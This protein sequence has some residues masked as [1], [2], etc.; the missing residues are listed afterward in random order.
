MAEPVT[1]G[2]AAASFLDPTSFGIGVVGGIISRHI[3]PAKEPWAAHFIA[4][5]GN[6]NRNGKLP[7]NHDVEAACFDALANTLR[8]L[9]HAIDNAIDRSKN[10]RDVWARKYDDRGNVRSWSQRWNSREGHWFEAFEKAIKSE[11]K[12][13]ELPIRDASDLNQ[14]V[15]SLSDEGLERSLQQGIIA[16]SREKVTSGAEPEQFETMVHGGWEV[17]LDGSSVSLSVYKIWCLFFQHEVNQNE[18]AFKILT[19]AWLGSIDERL[20]DVDSTGLLMVNSGITHSSFSFPSAD[21]RRQFRLRGTGHSVY[22]KA[23]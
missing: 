20:K 22:S 10:L 18:E 16:W 11:I 1:T 6:R 12:S 23:T 5:F 4:K 13:F 8:C 2:L 21:R 19:A 14:A 7:P 3:D 9:A 17:E 15:R